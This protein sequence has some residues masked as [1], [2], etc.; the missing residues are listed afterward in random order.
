M[1]EIFGG[2]CRR[3]WGGFE[4]G[5]FGGF[6]VSAGFFCFFWGG[7]GFW[8]QVMLLGLG[9][10]GWVVAHFLGGFVGDSGGF[11]GDFWGF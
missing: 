11:A 10:G 3:L 1:K 7:G 6:T 4:G 2:L 5:N 8:L 9:F